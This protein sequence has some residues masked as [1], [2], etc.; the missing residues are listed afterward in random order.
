MIF[1]KEL[2]YP[3]SVYEH[4]SQQT[5]SII[6]LCLTFDLYHDQVVGDDVLRRVLMC[7]RVIS[8][9]MCLPAPLLNAKLHVLH[10]Q[11]VVVF[12]ITYKKHHVRVVAFCLHNSVCLEWNDRAIPDVPVQMIGAIMITPH[13]ILLLHRKTCGMFCVRVCCLLFCPF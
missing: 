5:F 11:I 9:L 13:Q 1:G 7:N 2:L 8:L 6:N 4:M 12:R 3:T 10:V